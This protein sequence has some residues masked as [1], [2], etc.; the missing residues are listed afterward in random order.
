MDIL[1][2]QLETQD[3]ETIAAAFQ[4]LG[5]NKPVTQY[6]RYYA[7]QLQGKRTVLV[8]FLNNEFVGYLT[9]CWQSE[10]P[11]FRQA[12]IPEIKDFNVLPTFR[13]Q[14]I[15]TQLMGEAERMI[16]QRSAIVG[17]G[18]GLY[19]D[20]GAAQR[21]YVKRGYIPDG[22]GLVSHDRF[23]KPGDQVAVDDDLVLY[24]TKNTAADSI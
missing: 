10:Y 16:T 17:I 23:V 2:R 21:L 9:I 5:W 13:R 22:K 8:A 6:E 3:I 19:V 11:P 12:N 7:Q 14:G 20:Y 1:I 4:L 15:G 24:L 18:V